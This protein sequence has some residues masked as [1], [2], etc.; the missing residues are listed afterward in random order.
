MRTRIVI[1]FILCCSGVAFSQEYP[2]KFGYLSVEQGLSQ[3]SVMAIYQDREGFMWFGTRNGLNRYDGYR[4]QIFRESGKDTAP[5]SH[6]HIN[7][8]TG[9]K[10]GNVWVGTS[11]G[12]CRFDPV[13]NGFTKFF[14]SEND[15]AAIDGNNIVALLSDS[16]GRFWVV[17][18]NGLNY[19]DFDSSRFIRE[20][21]DGMLNANRI[22][23]LAEGEKGELWLGTTSGLIVFNTKTRQT[24]MFRQDPLNKRTISQNRISALFRDSSGNIWVGTYQQ[25]V[26]LYDRDR[27]CFIRYSTTDGL[28]DNNIRCFAEDSQGNLLIGTFDGL[29]AFNPANKHFSSIYGSKNGKR[30]AGH[31]SVYSILCDRAG[32]VWIGTYS[33][34]ICY[35]SPYNQRFRFYDPGMNN[36]TVFGIIGPMVEHP[37]GL[38][39]GTEGG[40]LLYFDKWKET[41][42]YFHLPGALPGAYGQNIVKSLLQDGDKLLVGTTRQSI[43]NFDM[44]RMKFD[45]TIF[46]PW[47]NY[48]YMLYKDKKSRL[49]IGG[50]AGEQSLGYITSDGHFVHP[51]SL[52]SGQ[53]FIP[54][55]VRCMVEDDRGGFFFGSWDQGLFYYDEPQQTVYNWTFSP[56]DTTG[57]PYHAVSS[58]CKTRKGDIWIGT[59]GGGLCLFRPNS[60]DFEVYN[61]RNGLPN[62]TVCKILEDLNGRLWISTLSGISELNLSSGRFTN[63][64]Y[65]NGVGIPEFTLGSGIVT[66]GNE[67][68][69]GGNNGFVS[70]HP[71]NITT[72]KYIPPVVITELMV[73]NLPFPI[74]PQQVI[75]LKHNQ[76]NLSIS[77]SALNFIYPNQNQYAYKLEGFDRDWNVVGNRRTAYY[78]N[79]PPGQYIFRV[80]GSN[81]DGV[82]NE[83]GTS[84][85]LF[86]ARPWW[87]TWWAW[88]FYVLVALSV[89]ATV[90]H[91]SRLK[92]RLENNIRIK[93]MEQE[94]M[95]ILHQTKIKLFT[96]FSHELRTPLTLILAPLEDLLQQSAL[97]PALHDTL[98][99]IFKNA[100]RLLY[101]VNQLMDFRKKESGH[102]RLKAAQGNLVKFIGE[103]VIAFNELASKRDIYFCFRCQVTDL[104]VWYD[105]NLLEKVLFNLLSNAFKNTP[106]QG[107]IT[108]SLSVWKSSEFCKRYPDKHQKSDSSVPEFVLIE[109]SD[110]GKGIPEEELERIF[111]SFYQVD[112]NETTPVSGTGIGLNLSR[113]IVEMHHGAIWAEKQSVAGAVFRVVLPLGNAHLSSEEIVENYQ[114]SEDISHYQINSETT[115]GWVE[116][117]EPGEKN[118]EHAVLI[119]EDNADVRYFIKSHLEKHYTVWEADNGTDALQ[120]SIDRLPCLIISDIMMPGMDGIQLCHALKND[121]R[122]GHIPLIL[123]TARVTVL[124]VQ[125]GF[126]VGADDYITKPFNASLLV[127]RVKNLIAS[128]E[129]LRLLFAQKSKELDVELPA[130]HIDNHFMGK[131]YNYLNLNMSNPEL[132]MDTFCKEIGMS[133]TNLYRKIKSLTNLSPSELIQNVRL[134]SALKLLQEND[135]SISEIAYTVGFSSPS[136][137]SKAFRAFFG[138]SPTEMRDRKA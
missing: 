50:T 19:Y 85:L 17:T 58:L 113:S 133:R 61:E 129:R 81:N 22:Y 136:Y 45:S 127:T 96:N 67:V 16:E 26:C 56:G 64:G 24:R 89:I 117:M 29:S 44:K 59:F 102:L 121:I 21:I 71:E 111:D 27:D 123:L 80:K 36:Q 6:N 78:T 68:F 41:Y 95:E 38:W 62:A 99:L 7:C 33:G 12:L 107:E 120:L 119:V 18:D 105:R 125:E 30:S 92:N 53:L 43:A 32:T 31:F 55:N 75:Y 98:N 34:G 11:G 122:T 10:N 37:D 108:I 104:Q 28:N 116:K 82:W 115:D 112:R 57:L 73:N 3:L 74:L 88:S 84:L 90:L 49:W 9:D 132:N 14:Y 63:Y 128:R 70:F 4:F 8:I 137:F 25:G 135:L 97:S 69:F 76:S 86:I 101:T 48:Y 47:S 60:M 2:I 23:A 65:D 42:T 46:P 138:I 15:S 5:I 110:T 54:P 1:M 72:N 124:Q 87:N 94:N 130:S 126:G 79:I 39:I 134:K 13:T 51:V 118:G 114:N 131:I 91:Y 20:S 66:S 40:G 93:Q 52:K 100:N 103:I 109:I 83:E 35:Y 77:F 106:D